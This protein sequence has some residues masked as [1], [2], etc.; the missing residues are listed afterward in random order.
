MALAI[1]PPV[2]IAIDA[3]VPGN[4][5]PN[6]KSYNIITLQPVYLIGS[7]IPWNDNYRYGC[8]TIN[9]HREI[10][11]LFA[12]TLFVFRHASRKCADP[13][14]TRTCDYRRCRHNALQ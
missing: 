10:L 5:F 7:T 12:H 9:H 4:D 1:L 13:R 14:K 3:N 2:L 6:F 8:A 11:I